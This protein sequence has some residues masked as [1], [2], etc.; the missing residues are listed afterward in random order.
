MSPCSSSAILQKCYT[1]SHCFSLTLSPYDICA[2][3]Y[4]LDLLGF[5]FML[6]FSCTESTVEVPAPF[7]VESTDPRSSKSAPRWLSVSSLSSS[8]LPRVSYVLDVMA[9]A[10]SFP[11]TTRGSSAGVR[12]GAATLL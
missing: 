3:Q 6:P 8:H 5:L 9:V 2:L 7:P 12:A 4:F 10:S 11:L 1:L